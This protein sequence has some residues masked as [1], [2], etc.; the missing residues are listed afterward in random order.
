MKGKTYEVD[1]NG[2]AMPV[3]EK[4]LHLKWE[5]WAYVERAEKSG[6]LAHC[7]LRANSITA[8]CGGWPMIVMPG[9]LL[10]CQ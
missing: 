9:L 2:N 3:T 8:G 6:Q 4:L 1:F 10:A 7:V 5:I